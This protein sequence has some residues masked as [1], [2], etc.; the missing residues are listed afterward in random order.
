MGLHI[1]Q[2]LLNNANYRQSVKNDLKKLEDYLKEIAEYYDP[3][4]AQELYNL[5][6][7]VE[8]VNYGT[9]KN[10]ENTLH[11]EALKFDKINKDTFVASKVVVDDDD[12]VDL[13]LEGDEDDMDDFEE[14][15]EGTVGA[16]IYYY[17]HGLISQINDAKNQV[18]GDGVQSEY[19]NLFTDIDINK[20][21]YLYQSDLISA[22]PVNFEKEEI[23]KNKNEIENNKFGYYAT[24]DIYAKTENLTLSDK[25]LKHLG[26]RNPEDWLDCVQN[27]AT[28]DECVKYYEMSEGTVHFNDASYA[29]GR[30]IVESQDGKDIDEN[31][32]RPILADVKAKSD[33]YKKIN[34]FRRALSYINPGK[35]AVRDLR[36]E[37]NDAKEILKEK[38]LNMKEL[39]AFLDGKA[40]VND[41]KVPENGPYETALNASANIFRQVNGVVNSAN[42]KEGLEHLKVHGI[43][44][45]DMLSHEYGEEYDLKAS[46]QKIADIKG[47]ELVNDENTG[48]WPV[49]DEV[50]KSME[51]DAPAE[52]EQFIDEEAPVRKD[53]LNRE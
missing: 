14:H 49:D 26:A 9:Y 52:S 48:K 33:E 39:D 8:N 5:L 2:K 15:L 4:H 38:N 36:N 21:A 29:M 47:V 35:D 34:W 3:S 20:I 16:N 30:L 37:I 28:I 13:K 10:E 11:F 6:S 51:V 44:L 42:Y 23:E 40:I 27:K 25:I 50:E 41:V 19:A 45:E 1:N 18:G 32:I 7:G 17:L 22:E 12:D 53:Q 24:S 43:E 46:M 31:N